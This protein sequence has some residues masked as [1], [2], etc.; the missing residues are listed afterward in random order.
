MPKKLTP[1]FFDI[2]DNVKQ[3]LTCNSFDFSQVM[4]A[5]C[6]GLTESLDC[7]CVWI[8][9]KETDG[10]ITCCAKA[11]DNSIC[12][13]ANTMRWDDARL[14]QNPAGLAIR[15]G[16]V[17]FSDLRGI[18]D[19]HCPWLFYMKKLQINTALAL[20]IICSDEE[21]LGV[22]VIYFR[23]IE[24][25][26]AEKIRILESF[27]SQLSLLLEMEK[28]SERVLRYSFLAEQSRDIFLFI[29]PDG[30]IV[31]ANTAAEKAYG[32]TKQELHTMNIFDLRLDNNDFVAKQMD[33]AASRGILFE[34]YHRRKD[35]SIFPVEVSSKGGE[36]KGGPLLLSVIRDITDRRKIENELKDSEERFKG[37]FNNMS[38]GVAVYTAD[39]Y[40]DFIFEEYNKSAEKIGQI[41]KEEVIG[42]SLTAVFPGVMESGNILDSLKRVWITGQPEHC[43][44]LR[45]TDKRI[46]RWTENYIFKLTS[47]EVVNVFRDITPQKQA[48]EELWNA[49]EHAH[50]TLKSI[51]D[52]VITTDAL[53]NIGFMNPVAEELT[54]WKEDDAKGLPLL[55]V[56]CIINEFTEL[57]AE[58]PVEKCLRTG[59]VVGLANHTI[60]INRSGERKHIED[61]ASPIRDREGNSIGAVLVFFDVSEKKKL[62]NELNY[63]AKYDSLTGLP[64]RVTFH[65][66]LDDVL[67]DSKDS[68][69]QFALFFI[70]IDRFKFINDNFGHTIGDELLIK[71]SKRIKFHLGNMDLV[72]RYGG[73]EF[74]IIINHV[75]NQEMVFEK[76]EKLIKSCAEIF[77]MQGKELYISISMGIALFPTHGK[78]PDSLIKHADLA[79]YSA[80]R[81]GGNKYNIYISEVDSEIFQRFTM[82][83]MLNKALEKGEFTL[84]Y[85]PQID[86]TTN[87]MVGVEALLRWFSPNGLIFPDEYIPFAEET[88]L[89][90][91]IGDWVIKEACRQCKRWMDQGYLPI[92]VAIN[93]SAKQFYQQDFVEKITKI[94]DQYQLS[95]VM[96]TLEI[97][98]SVAMQNFASASLIINKI[99]N[100]G[101]Q[102]AIDDFGT[103]Y[104]S[105]SY[106]ANMNINCLKIDKSMIQNLKTEEKK[107]K[108]TTAIVNLAKILQLE[109]IAEGI[110]HEEDILFLKE[111]HCDKAQGYYFSK[112]LPM[113]EIERLWIEAKNYMNRS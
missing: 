15:T 63:L 16:S 102:I 31:D 107:A 80:K 89:I 22:L 81:S 75:D 46:S 93:I 21:V 108:I 43:P 69:K 35:G 62:L 97:T 50:V 9:L 26:P 34:T 65:N 71:I 27:V 1:K 87:K 103:G 77:Y 106:L 56:F 91:P 29:R 73:D 105:L 30:T 113:E 14:G 51:G 33:S 7:P 52:A 104:S 59:R 78:N 13:E 39:E 92:R 109:V 45:Y 111:L 3:N 112:P 70:D 82:L 74:A 40:G 61:S 48:E 55:T 47:G 32:Y 24:G 19:N 25:Y 42:Q 18:H 12:L 58:D 90:I 36:F 86:L 2:L 54:G 8:G 20:P 64:N 49:K 23:D 57:P 41:K 10:T 85:Q 96:L 88:D 53:G 100:M 6:L 83:G 17:Q 28:R 95:P 66:F 60:L 38:D 72:C 84:Y 94:L 4:S 44:V 11:G 37:I 76:A 98:E 5:F 67:N 68:N 99:I 79:M 110:E 101:M